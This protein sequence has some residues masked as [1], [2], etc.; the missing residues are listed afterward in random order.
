MNVINV[1]ADRSGEVIDWLRD[2]LEAGGLLTW[3]ETDL[4]DGVQYMQWPVCHRFSTPV[5]PKTGTSLT[6]AP[7]YMPVL[8]KKALAVGV[9]IRYSTPGV[10]LIRQGT[11]RVTGIVA[12][13]KAGDYVQFNTSKGVVLAA[14]GYQGNG[15]MMKAYCPRAFDYSVSGGMPDRTGD[16]ILMGLWVG[17]AMDELPHA[18]MQFDS[19]LSGP[20]GAGWPWSGGSGF[21]RQPFLHV[22]QLGE[23]FAEEDGTY[24]FNC[25][26]GAQ[27][28]GHTWWKV[29]DESWPDDIR[30]FHTTICSRL[31]PSPMSYNGMANSRDMSKMEA[32]QD[33]KI[34]ALTT[35]I[36]GLVDGKFIKKANT[37]EELAAAMNVP[38]DSFKATVARYNDLA[39]LGKDLDYGKADFRLSALDKPPFYAAKYG[40]SLLSTMSGLKINNK[41]QVIDTNFKVI[42][43]LYAVGDNSGSF[44]G[45]DYAQFFG[46]LACG[47]TMTF[48]R[49]AA[50]NLAAEKPAT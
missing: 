24:Q 3:L 26:T 41:M 16:G 12:K 33:A 19:G 37:L 30:V 9:N 13:N 14:G 15:D 36:Q 22:N 48:G 34:K 45:N 1:W 4:K 29:W 38:V 39:K 28:P 44:F 11:G 17:A 7:A 2:I 47:R 21:W 31:I 5:D 25:N 10:Q 46:G 6:G 49:L 35:Q 50:L 42:P 32:E 43:G 40:A 23:R 18:P 20:K 27:Q 8:E